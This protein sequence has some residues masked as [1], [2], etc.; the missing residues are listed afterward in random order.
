MEL[1]NGHIHQDVHMQ[2]EGHV[3]VHVEMDEE[4]IKKHLEEAEKNKYVNAHISEEDEKF[5]IEL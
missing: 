5:R 2:E 1:D 4:S 3:I